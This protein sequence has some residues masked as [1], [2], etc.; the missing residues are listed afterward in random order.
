MQFQHP[1]HSIED[2][3]QNELLHQALTLAHHKHAAMHTKDEK[4]E[5]HVI[6]DTSRLSHAVEQKKSEQEKTEIMNRLSASLALVVNKELK[7]SAQRHSDFMMRDL[8]WIERDVPGVDY[9][10]GQMLQEG[11]FYYSHVIKQQMDNLFSK[12]KDPECHPLK[13][14]TS[15][16]SSANLFLRQL[17]NLQVDLLLAFHHLGDAKS[18]RIKI[19]GIEIPDGENK[20]A[21]IYE[22]MKIIEESPLMQNKQEAKKEISWLA[23]WHDET[24]PVVTPEFDAKDKRNKYVSQVSHEYVEKVK[25]EIEE[26]NIKIQRLD[27]REDQLNAFIHGP[28]KKITVWER[29]FGQGKNLH[30]TELSQILTQKTELQCQISLHVNKLDLYKSQKP[31]G[32]YRVKIISPSVTHYWFEWEF[33]GQLFSTKK[34]LTQEE[35]FIEKLESLKLLDEERDQLQAKLP[36]YYKQCARVH[37]LDVKVQTIDQR[38]KSYKDFIRLITGID[39]TSTSG[40][41]RAQ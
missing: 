7:T 14:G 27:Q 41:D 23:Q 12:K 32:T 37:S 5:L 36:E 15:E 19:F 24:G 9:L 40:T 16:R 11:I 22:Q 26:L 33:G 3:V 17:K 4:F 1:H 34:C 2:A 38:I 18:K 28:K 29:I 25:K 6:E 31:A 30:E 39:M 13:I 8:K 20:I 35:A 21:G 10:K